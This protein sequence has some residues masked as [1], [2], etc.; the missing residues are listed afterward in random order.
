MQ[1]STTRPD[2]DRPR[3]KRR[4]TRRPKPTGSSCET[5]QNDVD[6]APDAGAEAAQP[7]AAGTAREDDAWLAAAAIRALQSFF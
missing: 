7:S 3:R 6:S 4:K 5:T 2:G 1:R